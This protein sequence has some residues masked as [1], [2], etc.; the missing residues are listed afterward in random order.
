M[1]PVLKPLPLTLLLA[2]LSPAC[3][4]PQTQ[5]AAPDAGQL[6]DAGPADASTQ[7]SGLSDTGT[8]MPTG[9]TDEQILA[10]EW[11]RLADA[12]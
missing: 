5:V 8:T 10:T 11:T 9:P 7:D 12:R 1:A 2:A 3:G 6:A 4:G